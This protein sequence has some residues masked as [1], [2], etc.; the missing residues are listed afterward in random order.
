MSKRKR[1]LKMF[2]M[3]E[4]TLVLFCSVVLPITWMVE[5]RIW[6]LIQPIKQVVE[7]L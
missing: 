3:S 5:K 4:I 1:L 7:R 2:V 6:I